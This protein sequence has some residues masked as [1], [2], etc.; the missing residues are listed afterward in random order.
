MWLGRLRMLVLAETRS[1]ARKL[2]SRSVAKCD[3]T[4]RSAL[5]RMVLRRQLDKQHWREDLRN[6]DARRGLAF[7][8]WHE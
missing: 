2:L 4:E 7:G 5:K 1:R 3:S 6:F 8:Q